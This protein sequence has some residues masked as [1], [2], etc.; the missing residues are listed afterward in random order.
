MCI[1]TSSVFVITRL[2]VNSRYRGLK[3]IVSEEDRTMNK[4]RCSIKPLAAIRQLLWVI[5]LLAAV[6]SGGQAQSA[7][8]F[9]VY[10]ALPQSN[11]V[12]VVDGLTNTVL[13]TIAIPTNTATGAA[14]Q[15]SSLALT[16]DAKYLYV[17]ATCSGNP[18]QGSVSVVDTVSDII[19][20][21][22]PLA[23][24][25]PTSIAITPDGTRAYMTNT[26][27]NT[28]EVEVIDT[29]ANVVLTNIPVTEGAAGLAINP[30]GAHVYVATLSGMAVIG[31]A[32][33]TVLSNVS[34]GPFKGIGCTPNTNQV[35]VTPNGTQVYVTD[36][37]C[38][39]FA[40]VDTSLALS[41]PSTSQ[42]FIG[43]GG[44]LCTAGGI[45]I[46]PDGKNA[47]LLDTGCPTLYVIDTTT[48]G[49]NSS[50]LSQFIP[51]FVAFSSDSKSAYLSGQFVPGYPN[52]DVPGLMV[53]DTT[54]NIVP[55]TLSVS[56]SGNPA[57][58]AVSPA[59]NTPTGTEILVQPLDKITGTSPVTVTFADVTQ[60][61]YTSLFISSTGPTPPTGFEVAGVYYN[62]S[63]TAQFTGDVT[64][65]IT[66]PMVTS[67]S[68]LEHFGSGGSSNITSS[69]NPPT[70]CGIT[71][72]FS[73]FAI[74]EPTGSTSPSATSTTLISSANPS[75]YGQPLMFTA[76]VSTSVGTPTGTVSFSDGGTT[77]TTSPLNGSD[78]ATFSA[79]TLGA[80][81]HLITAS[82]SGDSTF[83][84]SV[85]SAVTQIV[86]PAPLTVTAN[87]LTIQ[88]GQ[89]N[90]MFTASYSG[91]VNGDNPGVLSGV[92][93]CVS[94]AMP[95]SPVGTYAINCS[96]LSSPNYLITNVPGTL[97]VTPA[98]LVIAANSASR[99]YGANNPMLTG[100]ISGLQNG[101][102]ISAGF[103]TSATPT[104]PVGS[105]AIVPTPVGAANV[106]SNY[107]VSLVNGTLSIIPET[108]SLTVALS[109]LSIP[110][111]QSTTATVILTAPDMVIP[112]DP[113]VLAAITL[114][115]PVVSDILSNNG[116]CT[117][118][119]SA[120]PGMA[121]CTITITSVEPNGRTLN[122]S[123]VGSADLV[124]STGTADLI[125]TAAL[126][127]QQVCIKSDFRNV[128][129]PGGS[130][131]WFNSIFKVRDVSKQ[132]IHVSFFQSTAQFQY[133]DASGN[134]VTVNQA[135]PDAHITIDPSAT[136]ASTAFDSVNNVWTTTIPWDLDDSSFLTGMPWL[137]PSAGLP[138]DVE[139]VT[140]CGTFASDVAGIDIGWRWSAAAYSSFSS[141]STTLGVKPMDTDSDNPGS[142]HDLAGTPEN[143]KQFVI[144]GARG[145]GG[146]NYTGTYSGS[147]EI[148]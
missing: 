28:A 78:L 66:S 92:L 22:I 141:D 9:K 140:V 104:S 8:D 105:Y 10:V 129:V 2:Q 72:S 55:A 136:A 117:P 1:V 52:P 33:N 41:S 128:A 38:G 138:A 146:K 26:L 46:T 57:G 5:A 109:P 108:T 73:P 25:C 127:S 16:P 85:S 118:A 122:A 35:A 86:N 70:I 147:K 94:S 60:P 48:Y 37:D 133:T 116:V 113:S 77:L 123:F 137:V 134:V 67:G 80:G 106:L 83:A 71:S 42:L 79:S 62:L 24:S 19:V 69:V 27:S 107:T 139:P 114:T 64:I 88:Y 112:I 121:T 65:C 102:L 32:T 119:P 44:I 63:T 6:P 96:G 15:P 45:A 68:T 148:E 13:S 14:T 135:M 103:S 4:N 12:A 43:P 82:Y 110:V 61:G 59:N 51:Y 29:S 145:K 90:P 115:S 34:L 11:I 17:L 97:T 132:L 143:Y 56:L 144:P 124:T 120:T 54:T 40:V 47:Y 39:S 3:G 125:V 74:L 21:T 75:V 99:P 131:L 111:G 81:R 93:S 30:D 31:T 84:S 58:M 36:L 91:F 53:V 23:S 18:A 20:A 7:P 98:P 101:D 50:D 130:Y 126:Q 49:Y 87:N 142:N 95:S 89:A 100:A 76:A